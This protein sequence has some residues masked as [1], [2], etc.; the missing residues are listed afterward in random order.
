MERVKFGSE[1]RFEIVA[2]HCPSCR[3]PHQ[4]YHEYGCVLESCPRCGGRL[5][6][7]SCKAL[8]IIDSM[9]TARA[10]ANSITDKADIHLVLESGSKLLNQTYYEEGCMLWIIDDVIARDPEMAKEADKHMAD[11]G[12]RKAKGGYAVR[13]EDVAKHMDIPTDKAHEVLIELHV[14][15]CYPDWD[16]QTGREC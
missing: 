3:T 6:T 16:K 8:G 9:K 12:F 10:V 15:S 13:A 7:C 2:V 11:L 4:Q 14:D 5:L 1:T